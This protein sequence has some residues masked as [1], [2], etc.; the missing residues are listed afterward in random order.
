MESTLLN[1]VAVAP[2]TV[3]LSVFLF[4]MRNSQSFFLKS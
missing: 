3:K 4:I 1:T 2:D